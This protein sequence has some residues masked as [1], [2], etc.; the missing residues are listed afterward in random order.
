M[1]DDYVPRASRL[2]IADERRVPTPTKPLVSSS[3]SEPAHA[4]E[5]WGSGLSKETVERI[6]KRKAEREKDRQGKKKE[7]RLEDIPTFL[8]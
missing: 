5:E 3:P 6:A 2:N 8:V 4:N 7:I 1:L